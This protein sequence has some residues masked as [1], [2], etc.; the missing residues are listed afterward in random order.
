MPKTEPAEKTPDVKRK[1]IVT[2]PFQK[3]EI[4]DA[5]TASAEINEIMAGPN[6]DFVVAVATSTQ[7]S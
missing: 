1:L 2:S 3:Y 7:Q 6:Q 5:I 4:G